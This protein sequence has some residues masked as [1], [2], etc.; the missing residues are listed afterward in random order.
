MYETMCMHAA[1]CVN[2]CVLLRD[3]VY[4]SISWH[5]ILQ[6]D[7]CVVLSFFTLKIHLMQSSCADGVQLKTVLD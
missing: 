2:M 5:I 3:G 6:A 7:G 1:L 4:H